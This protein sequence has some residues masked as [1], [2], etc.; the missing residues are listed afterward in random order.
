[1]VGLM[2]HQ[3][4]FICTHCMT[5]RD[6]SRTF[7]GED[8]LPRQVH[9]T[10]EEQMTA[11]L[12]CVDGGRLRWRVA[13]ASSCSA[14]PFVL[15]HAAVHGLGTGSARSYD[16]VSFHTLHVW[17][18]GV[19]RT[20]AQDLPAMLEA[21]FEGHSALRG[22][23]QD[24]LDVLNMRGFEPGR[25]C[26]AWP[27]SPGD[28]PF[29]PAGEPTHRLSPSVA[30]HHS[31][32]VAHARAVQRQARLAEFASLSFIDLPWLADLRLFPVHCSAPPW[33]IAFLCHRCFVPRSVKQPT[34]KGHHWRHFCVEW[35]HMVTGPVGPAGWR[36]P[37]ALRVSSRTSLVALGRPVET[38]G[39][40]SD[41]SEERWAGGAHR[42]RSLID[43]PNYGELFGHAFVEDA[44][45][46]TIF[47][48]AKLN[49]LLFGDNNANPEVTTDTEAQEMAHLARALVGTIQVL[50]GEMQ[51]TKLHRMLHH[52]LAELQKVG[53]L[54]ERDTSLNEANHLSIK[55]MFRRTNRVGSSLL[56]HILRAIETQTDVLQ[57]F[58]E[59]ERQADRDAGL[60][61]VAQDVAATVVDGGAEKDEDTTAQLRA[62]K[63]GV[64]VSFATVEEQPGLAGLTAV[65]NVP[66]T[67]TA[68]MVNTIVKHAVFEWGAPS[69]RQQVRCAVRFRGA[70]WFSFIRYKDAAGQT[71]WGMVKVV[72]RAVACLS[73]VVWHRM[74][75]AE[76]NLT[77]VLTELGC[78]RLAWDFVSPRDEW[79]RLEDVELSSVLR[80]GQVHFDWQDLAERNGLL[81]MPLT[82]PQTAEERR[83][84]RLFTN[85]SHPWTTR[86]RRYF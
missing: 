46:H 6:D 24:T 45:L 9:S 38:D 67:S 74:R 47:Q 8:A 49:N 37:P 7:R 27:I 58:E 16:V 14:L 5:R 36:E 56:L 23:M 62:S 29:T 57:T 41:A 86:A 18:L 32:L 64:T 50:L 75:R 1:M 51:N 15:V 3:C 76:A 33:S 84:T 68:V 85:V 55:A 65:F 10:L 82:L 28:V 83:A 54:W 22:C 59:E 30:L 52:M 73:C 60:S 70:P 69:V 81:A 79:P 44:I 2:G 80:L 53:N 17:K 48:A 40:D 34:M 21:V 77:C 35:P 19:V 78:Q 11:T 12:S 63:R 4:M 61:A 31:R 72:L 42:G 66:P 71:Q 25:L 13:L 20:L 43:D 39:G 26:R